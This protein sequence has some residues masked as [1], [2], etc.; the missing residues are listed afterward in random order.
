MNESLKRIKKKYKRCRMACVDVCNLLKFN[1][2]Y[3]LE[4]CNQREF[5]IVGLMRTGN[6][7]IINWLFSML[8]EPKCFLNYVEPNRNPFI[9]FKRKG[10]LTQ[11]PQVYFQKNRIKF[12]QLGLLRKKNALLYSYED[13][14]LDKIFTDKFALNHDRWVGKSRKKY[15]VL[16]LRDP[17]NLFA[18]RLKREEKHKNR[19][20]LK[21]ENERRHVIAIWKQYAREFLGETNHLPEQKIMI[22]YN[23]WITSDEYRSQLVNELQMNVQKKDDVLEEFLEIGGG[24]SFNNE[25]K[26]TLEELLG[27]WKKYRNNSLFIEIFRDQEL[28][29]LSNKIFGEI[30]GIREWLAETIDF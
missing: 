22:N 27:R 17:F 8:D 16:L 20:S 4:Y 28:I 21:D 19:Y 6:H 11:F 7:V 18:S 23:E 9:Y 25:Q 24:S 2:I 30:P 29:E 3:P 14:Y 26:P 5:R 1:L 13:E 15:N 12:E 10:T